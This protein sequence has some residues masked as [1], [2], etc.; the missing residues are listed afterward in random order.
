MKRLK[1]EL[2]S[3][4]FAAGVTALLWPGS[5][6]QNNN[7]SLCLT[8]SQ[9]RAE[10]AAYL[11]GSPRAQLEHDGTRWSVTDGETT[12]WLDARTGQLLEVRFSP[13]QEH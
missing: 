3:L 1:I 5:E 13:P 6:T 10:S 11:H 9:A 8:E 2:W 12:A 7:D 4:G